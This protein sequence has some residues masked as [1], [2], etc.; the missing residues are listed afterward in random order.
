MAASTF[1][2]IMR[3][4][5]LFPV[6]VNT[7]VWRPCIFPFYMANQAIQAFMCPVQYKERVLCSGAARWEEDIVRW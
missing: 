2:T 4:R 1:F 3:V 5:F 6:A 7:K